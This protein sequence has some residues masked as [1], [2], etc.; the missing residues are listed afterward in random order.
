MSNVQLPFGILANN[1]PK[2]AYVN[3]A[4]AKIGTHSYDC[5]HTQEETTWCLVLPPTGVCGVNGMLLSARAHRAVR[6]GPRDRNNA[7]AEVAAE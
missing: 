7:S 3:K 1:E 4:A 2:R 6:E 5:T